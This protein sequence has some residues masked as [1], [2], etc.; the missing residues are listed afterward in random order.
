MNP[1]FNEAR[2]D[3]FLVAIKSGTRDTHASISKLNPGK[4]N[5]R[6]IPERRDKDKFW[7]WDFG[8]WIFT[9]LSATF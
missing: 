3:V 8:F 6:R 9:S 1:N 4:I 7:I 5:I 2:G